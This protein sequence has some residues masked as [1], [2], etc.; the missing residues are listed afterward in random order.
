MTSG[1]SLYTAQQ[2]RRLSDIKLR[3]IECRQRSGT[4][5]N[6]SLLEQD[7][8]DLLDL[9]DYALRLSAPYLEDGAQ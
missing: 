6:M 8:D 7:R 9:L 4:Y 3:V 2:R 1:D 5:R